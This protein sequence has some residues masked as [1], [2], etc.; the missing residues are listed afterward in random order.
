MTHPTAYCRICRRGRVIVQA[1]SE[2]TK[3]RYRED[4]HFCYIDIPPPG[5]LLDVEFDCGHTTSVVTTCPQVLAVA[6]IKPGY[7]AA[8][9]RR[10]EEAT[11][12][13]S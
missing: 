8:W 12:Q 2:G 3:T 10:K 13:T 1:N 4:G 6:A 11:C 9:V 5:R 7:A